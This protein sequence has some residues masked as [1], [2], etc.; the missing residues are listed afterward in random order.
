MNSVLRKVMEYFR[1]KG[2]DPVW[3]I[4]LV[5]GL[6]ILSEKGNIKNRKNLDP[7]FWKLHRT[8]IGVSILGIAIL[9]IGEI[10]AA[11]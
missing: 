2:I 6:L 10:F 1:S 4:I 9:I 7:D 3:I 8:I 5:L 11:M